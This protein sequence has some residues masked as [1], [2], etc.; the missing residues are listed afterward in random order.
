MTVKTDLSEEVLNTRNEVIVVLQA[1]KTGIAEKIT[2]PVVVTLPLQETIEAP[3]FDNIAY[4]ADYNFDDN[5]VS[6][7]TIKVKETDISQI[8]V[9]I[10]SSSGI[11]CMKVVGLI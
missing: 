1:T 2:A 6:D 11:W 8:D 7:N 10:D 9:T 3:Q 4:S 5:T